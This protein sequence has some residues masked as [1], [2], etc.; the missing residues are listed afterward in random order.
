MKFI[1][2]GLGLLL[3]SAEKIAHAQRS[4]ACLKA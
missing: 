3:W 2:L 1:V 4:E